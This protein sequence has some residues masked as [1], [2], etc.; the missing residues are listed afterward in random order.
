[1]RSSS[2]PSD[3]NADN[4]YLSCHYGVIAG[5]FITGTHDTPTCLEGLGGRTQRGT[6]VTRSAELI[7]QQIARP[8]A[9]AGTGRSGSSAE[10]A[11]FPL[12]DLL[13][14]DDRARSTRPGTSTGNWC[15]GWSSRIE[16]LRDPL[17]GPS[18]ELAV[19]YGRGARMPGTARL[20]L[21]RRRNAEAARRVASALTA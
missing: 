15:G 20:S 18:G 21:S 9:V 12:Q 6:G 2:S 5:W 7:G 10:L 8:V 14:L 19:R 11:M 16:R 4:A 13:H 3:G 1:M 17:Q